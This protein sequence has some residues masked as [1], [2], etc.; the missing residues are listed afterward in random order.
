MEEYGLDNDK[1]REIVKKQP[2]MEDISRS[3]HNIDSET[4]FEEKIFNPIE[5]DIKSE[6]FNG[7]RIKNGLNQPTWFT[8]EYE[9]E[10]A[11]KKRPNTKSEDGSGKFSYLIKLKEE[12]LSYS[13]DGKYD[14]NKNVT[15]L[16]F[17]NCQ[18]PRN[19]KKPK[20]KWNFREVMGFISE[21]IKKEIKIGK[22]ELEEK[23]ENNGK[24]E[25]SDDIYDSLKI[26]NST[27]QH[28][29]IYRNSHDLYEDKY[30]EKNG[31]LNGEE[32]NKKQEELNFMEK[33]NDDREDIKQYLTEIMVE[34]QVEHGKWV[35]IKKNVY[36]VKNTFTSDNIFLI[37]RVDPETSKQELVIQ[38]INP[39]TKEAET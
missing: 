12:E 10:S 34:E 29:N 25:A 3:D 16:S 15:S 27:E 4:N 32:I 20:E 5:F 11:R 21:K 37:A 28:K 22:K 14:S 23:K 30:M 7:A 19:P 38:K 8:H 24:N 17:N 1:S 13:L 31:I 2:I 26:R 33:K 9:I 6:K 35:K 39:K 18:I 36:E